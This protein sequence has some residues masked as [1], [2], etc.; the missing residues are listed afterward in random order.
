MTTQ[1]PLT[2]TD[3]V[4]YLTLMDP[5]LTNLQ[6]QD[7]LVCLGLAECTTFTI[8]HMRRTFLDDVRFLRR[9]G[10]LNDREPLIPSRIRRLKPPKEQPP[11]R[12]HFGR[13]SRDD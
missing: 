11:F 10:L 8:S 13:Q 3:A 6:I 12:Y 7:R 1:R 4:R 5:D 9:I 2:V